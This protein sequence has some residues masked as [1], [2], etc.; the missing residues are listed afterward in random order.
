[1]SGFD[2]VARWRIDES[3][4]EGSNLQLFTDAAGCEAPGCVSE[5]KKCS[6]WQLRRAER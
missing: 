2:F 5:I 4:R 3:I 6:R 1:M